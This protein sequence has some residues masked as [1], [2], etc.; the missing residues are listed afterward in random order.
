MKDIAWDA[1]QLFIVIARQGGLTAAAD[2]TGLSPATLGRRMVELEQRLGRELFLRSQTGYRLTLDGGQL[3]EQLSELE[4]ASRKVEE[5]RRGTGGQA[6][7]RISLGTWIAWL[8]A[9]NMHAIRTERDAFRIDMNVA[10]Q[11]ARLAHRESDIGIRAFEPEEPN[12]ASVAAGEVA[13][14]V[15][16]ARNRDW[17]GAEPWLAV[18]TENAVSNYLRWPHQNKPDRIVVTANRPRSLLDLVRAGAGMAILPCFVGDLDPTLE[19]TGEEIAALRHRQWI[20]MNNDDRHRREIRIV[21]DRM[22]KLLGAHK[23]LLA[24]RRPSKTG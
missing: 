19:R 5:W 7:V 8:V 21:V 18:D 4:A 9:Q 17:I 11:R 2:A 22:A 24:G 16:R 20:V 1:Y 14:A 3:L 15:Y 10:E 12:L 13:Y 6:L 23:D